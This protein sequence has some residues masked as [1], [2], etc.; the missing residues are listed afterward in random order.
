[1]TLTTKVLSGLMGLC[2]GDALGVPVEFTSR[3]ERIKSPVTK[4]LG[5]GTWNQPPGTW[6]DES[7]LMLC[8]AASLCNGYSVDDIGQSFWRWYRENYWTAHGNVFDIGNT[9]YQAIIKLEKGIPDTFNRDIPRHLRYREY[10][11]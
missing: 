8:L 3:A 2:V 11:V 9:T 10:L 4:M 5:Y 6:S 7:S 1:M